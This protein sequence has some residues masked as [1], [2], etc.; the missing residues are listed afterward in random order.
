MD[1]INTYLESNVIFDKFKI[2]MWNSY[3]VQLCYMYK[4]ASTQVPG[5]SVFQTLIIYDYDEWQ[6][7]SHF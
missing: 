5:I 6:R 1:L 2:K 7:I 3:S 4:C